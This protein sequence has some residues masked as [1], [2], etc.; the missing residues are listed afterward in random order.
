MRRPNLII[1][2]I[3]FTLVML[4]VSAF[5]Q[6]SDLSSQGLDEP[7]F[8]VDLASFKSNLDDVVR[9]EIYYKIYNDGLKFFK[10]G[11]EFIADYELNI[12]IHN[13]I[14]NIWSPLVHFEN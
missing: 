10:K 1:Q 6:Y 3:L 5:G 12:T 7:R 11:E 8:A 2:M 9:L 13:P 14:C 4:S